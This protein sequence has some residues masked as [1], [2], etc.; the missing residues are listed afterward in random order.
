M[1]RLPTGHH[2]NWLTTDEKAEREDDEAYSEE[3]TE[4]ERKEY[5]EYMSLSLAK[6]RIYNSL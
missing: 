1:N 3:L 4:S 5:D 2:D 6:R